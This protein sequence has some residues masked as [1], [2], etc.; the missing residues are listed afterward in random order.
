MKAMHFSI[1]DYQS[2]L[3]MV[4]IG[5]WQIELSTGMLHVHGHGFVSGILGKQG[6]SYA[7]TVSAYMEEFCHPDD[8]AGIK[9]NLAS[10]RQRKEALKFEHRL[11]HQGFGKWI[12]V[13]ISAHYRPLPGNSEGCIFGSL[14]NVDEHVRYQQ[15][16]EEMRKAEE[17]TQIMLDATPLCCNF[18][19]E[20]FNNV[21]CN[22]EAVRLFDLSS[23]QEYLDRFFELSPE[24]QPDGHPSAE[25]A[26]E[27]IEI[28][29]SEGAA[30]FEWMHQK[31]N[32]EP[33]P[34]EITLVRVRRGDGYIVAGYTRDLRELKAMLAEMRKTEDE[35]RLARDFAEKSARAKSEFLANMSHEIRTPM[36]AILGMTHFLRETQLDER[37]RTF[38]ENADHS[39]NLLLRIIN[40]ILDFS[41]IEAGRLEMEHIDFSLYGLLGNVHD[42]VATQVAAKSLKLVIEIDPA[43]PE[44]L[45]GDPL[46]LEQ[47]LINLLN[48]AIKFTQ[49][50]VV[51]I[52]VSCVYGQ[53]GGPFGSAELLFEVKDTG[54][55]MTAAQVANLFTPFTQADTSTTR[56]Y[57]G[58]GLGL[59]ISRS[60]VGLMG[61]TIWCESH[62]GEGSKFSFTGIFPLAK[63][64]PA[65]GREEAAE[66]SATSGT[67]GRPDSAGGSPAGPAD[68]SSLRGLRVLLAE[69]NE[70]NQMIAV[71]LL[72][73]K[74][75][76]V[77]AVGTGKE[78]LEALERNEYD[79]ILMD[80]QMPEM[81]GLTATE[82]LRADPRYRS[83]PVIAM[84]AHAMAGDREISIRSGMNDHITK[85][86]DPQALYATLARWDRRGKR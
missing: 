82:H 38:V 65:E 34:A 68:Y 33:I 72:T 60:L 76:I 52:H 3:D 7:T 69:D 57:G 35:L 20:N 41:K 27:Y 46:R 78:A 58:T 79:L 17:R 54:I 31:L 19:D 49:A 18:W 51:A 15:T 64:V 26:K 30:K 12:W 61:G 25:M 9:E 86:I 55:G 53:C 59:A 50:G 8:V 42:I 43:V 56:K 5:L 63:A 62:P 21:D 2:I 23:K 73:A 83:L 1:E 40:D 28:A 36:N 37:Q 74:G 70:I 11:W 47:V 13:C 67:W 66:D 22:Q 39:A 81:D 4:K 84:T 29:F 44:F 80:I 75:I 14:Q 77:D 85:P 10:V 48:N 16:L 6:G 24:Y 71:E 45:Q 32:G